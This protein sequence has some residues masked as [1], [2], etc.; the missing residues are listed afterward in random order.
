MNSART[1]TLSSYDP[2]VL[3]NPMKLIKS[4]KVD[5]S[6]YEPYVIMAYEGILITVLEEHECDCDYC[7]RDSDESHYVFKDEIEAKAKLT[8]FN[9]EHISEVKPVFIVKVVQQNTEEVFA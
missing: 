1:I 4:N 8:R 3:F 5:L 7:D 2:D 6:L 9:Y